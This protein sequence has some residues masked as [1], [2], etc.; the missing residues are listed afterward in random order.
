[1]VAG[2]RVFLPFPLRSELDPLLFSF[3]HVVLPRIYLLFQCLT[4]HVMSAVASNFWDDEESISQLTKICHTIAILLNHIPY[5]SLFPVVVSDLIY[6]S[7]DLSIWLEMMNRMSQDTD[8]FDANMD[9]L[10]IAILEETI[11]MID[12]TIF[13]SGSGDNGVNKNASDP[14]KPEYFLHV[15]STSQSIQ[16]L[17]WYML[18]ILE[19]LLTL[20]KQKR[21]RPTYTTCMILEEMDPTHYFSC[22]GSDP[23]LFMTNHVDVED[24]QTLFTAFRQIFLSSTSASN[25]VP[26][27][28]SLNIVSRLLMQMQSDWH[29]SCVPKLALLEEVVLLVG[30]GVRN[31]L[32]LLP[33]TQEALN[34]GGLFND[35]N[36]DTTENM[37]R[38]LSSLIYCP[39]NV[40]GSLSMYDV[41]KRIHQMC[42]EILLESLP[43]VLRISTIRSSALEANFD[44]HPAT[45]LS[46]V[47]LRTIIAMQSRISGASNMEFTGPL[48][49]ILDDQ[50][51]SE[52]AVFVLDKIILGSKHGKSLVADL[53]DAFPDP[54]LIQPA[55]YLNKHDEELAGS[56]RQSVLQ[57]TNELH[58]QK[59]RKNTLGHAYDALHVFSLHIELRQFF[60]NEIYVVISRLK[61]E[62][63]KS[64]ASLTEPWLHDLFRVTRRF[65]LV[66]LFV[67]SE[68]SEI[69][70]KL[71]AVAPNVF[72][73]VKDSLSLISVIAERLLQIEVYQHTLTQNTCIAQFV[74]TV[75]ICGIYI[76]KCSWL[77]CAGFEIVYEIVQSVL[78]LAY[79]WEI[80]PNIH[81]DPSAITSLK[82][83]SNL[84]DVLFG[85]AQQRI[86]GITA[87]DSP[88]STW[89]LNVDFLRILSATIN[90]QNLD[91]III[92]WTDPVLTRVGGDS[93]IQNFRLA[94]LSHPFQIIS[95]M[96][97]QTRQRSMDALQCARWDDPDPLRRLALWQIGSWMIQSMTPQ[98]L[99]LWGRLRI[100]DGNSLGARLV[101]FLIDTAFLDEN[102]TVLIFTSRELGSVLSWKNWISVLALLSTV[103]EWQ[104]TYNLGSSPSGHKIS[105]VMSRL[106]HFI[107]D[108]LN[109]QTSN[110]TRSENDGVYDNGATTKV[111]L[112]HKTSART[113]CSLLTVNPHSTS[114]ATKVATKHSMLLTVRQWSRLYL[115]A[116]RRVDLDGFYFAGLL[117]VAHCTDFG[118]AV[119]S[120][121]W[122]SFAPIMV[123]EVFTANS[124]GKSEHRADLLEKTKS[125]WKERQF[126]AFSTFIHAIINR[127]LGG[128]SHLSMSL[129]TDL[130]KIVDASL[131]G[132]MAELVVAEDYCGMQ[133]MA[134]YKLFV[135]GQKRSLS[136]TLKRIDPLSFQHNDLISGFVVGCVSKNLASRSWNRDLD[137][138]TRQLCL[139]PGLVEKIIPLIFMRSGSEELNFF[140]NTVLQKK[141][142]LRQLV[143]S[144]EM[145]TLKNFVIE[146]GSNPEQLEPMIVALK[147]A[148]I[149]RSDNYNNNSE[150]L[151]NISLSSND[152][153]AMCWVTQNFMFL[154]VNVVQYKWYTKNVTQKVASLTSLLA[155]LSFLKPAD[156][157]QYLP[158]I[159]ATVT[160]ALSSA[161]ST[162]HPYED[163]SEMKQLR[164][165]AIHVLSKFVKLVASSQLEVLGQNLTSVVVSL[166]PTL[167]NSDCP[168]DRSGCEE[169]RYGVSLL[170]WLSSQ[171]SLHQ[172]F[173]EIPFLPPTASLDGVRARL[174]ARGVNFD[175][176]LSASTEA[177]QD[178]NTGTRSVTSDV[179]STAGDSRGAASNA[180]RQAALRRRLEMISPL[181]DNDSASVRGV[182]LQHL[183]SLLR[184]NRQLFH[185]LIENE[186]TTSFKRFVT[187]F[188]RDNN[189]TLVI[190]LFQPS[191]KRSP[192]LLLFPQANLGGTSRTLF[193]F[194]FLVA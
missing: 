76:D 130:E 175:H 72:R 176:L 7:K 160:T 140:T 16:V 125:S 112:F 137:N 69:W 162:I 156:S 104:H 105:D 116:T 59:R 192:N 108:I 18:M 155:I 5:M 61:V 111:E 142:S 51:L 186:G 158:Q 118:S 100:E 190:R 174:K 3:V 134:G 65:Q 46:T 178:G 21:L 60:G 85:F 47:I 138:H 120:E 141:I 48:F 172:Y 101:K 55:Q 93:Q 68:D 129:E 74:K 146:L 159:M 150:S 89:I 38:L 135:L 151:R 54:L 90:S 81:E 127:K 91:R 44:V 124:N 2:R 171:E 13:N 43:H 42:Y 115:S 106:F 57:S 194:Y 77:E 182:A 114:Q 84:Y 98:E 26:A 25:V 56:K 6:L 4:M 23:D 168:E 31:Y 41:T 121:K 49:Q 29:R 88:Q 32:E 86:G 96:I 79:R 193:M 37:A 12:W 184:S 180:I 136:K 35:K 119:L 117:R 131:P 87:V 17:Q 14:T 149:V 152:D 73:F 154:L 67:Q 53:D 122:S 45:A 27:C 10:K 148:A 165:L 145:L 71:A 123:R 95:S 164:V 62:F 166:I 153:A 109:A 126:S 179:G 15:P 58:P 191:I 9:H 99:Q 103:E 110:L 39:P 40:A 78:C 30:H 173:E 24:V 113:L 34:V 92:H 64:D 161:P 66:M 94:T 8:V 50:V 19:H 167:T 181:L 11:E 102:A 157:S 22:M 83:P 75:V 177:T 36:N 185:S 139:A 70:N 132:A 97:G 133:M 107:D 52:T 1:M 187:V 80:S 147:K 183:T 144:R 189:G 163:D 170:E 188:Y 143:T 20:N 33:T 82:V 169:E 63:H 128:E 28:Y